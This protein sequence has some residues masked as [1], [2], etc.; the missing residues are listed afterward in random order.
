MAVNNSNNQISS[1]RPEVRSD[2]I[3]L[4]FSEYSRNDNYFSLLASPVLD[5]L[6]RRCQ[7]SPKLMFYLYIFKERNKVCC[8]CSLYSV[9]KL[10]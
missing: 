8:C 10:F 6:L 3:F 1:P 5:T 2:F 4:T 9:S 7:K